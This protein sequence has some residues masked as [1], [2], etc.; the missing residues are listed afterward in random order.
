MLKSSL[1]PL[2]T[3]K[4]YGPVAICLLTKYG[5]VVAVV[6]YTLSTSTPS[7]YKATNQ[8]KENEDIQK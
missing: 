1:C 3:E 6:I 5:V 8:A 2:H 4:V 7:D